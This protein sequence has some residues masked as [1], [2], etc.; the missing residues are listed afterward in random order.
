MYTII[1]LSLGALI[2]V[3]VVWKLRGN[4]EIRKSVESQEQRRKIREGA[5]RTLVWLQELSKKDLL[6]E[7]TDWS[8]DKDDW[9]N[10]V[11]LRNEGKKEMIG[12]GTTNEE[13]DTLFQTFRKKRD[14]RGM[15]NHLTC[16]LKTT[17][18]SED[19]FY[20]YL[21]ERNEFLKENGL[22]ASDFGSNENTPDIEKDFFLRLAKHVRGKVLVYISKA[23]TSLADLKTEKSTLPFKNEDFGLTEVRRRIDQLLK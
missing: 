4:Y 20:Y 10:L 3:V 17:D 23:E 21:D 7:D 8:V 1:S 6:K 5:K 12:L 11:D 9:T 13:V 14:L 19:M 16:N 22:T 2:L 18:Y 15:W